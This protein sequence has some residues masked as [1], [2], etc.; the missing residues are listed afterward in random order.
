MRSR[1]AARGTIFQVEREDEIRNC[2]GKKEKKGKRGEGKGG[3]RGGGEEKKGEGKE[4]EVQR[5][6]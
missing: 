4:G 1:L 6:M 2:I 5:S 3:G